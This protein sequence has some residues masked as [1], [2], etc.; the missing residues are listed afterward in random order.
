MQRQHHSFRWSSQRNPIPMW[1]VRERAA[2]QLV[3]MQHSAVR[4]SCLWRGNQAQRRRHW[5]TL[6]H[7]RVGVS[8]MV[9]PNYH[10]RPLTG[11]TASAGV[12]L[13]LAELLPVVAVIRVVVPMSCTVVRCHLVLVPQL[14]GLLPK[15][16]CLLQQVMGTPE[17]PQQLMGTPEDPVDTNLCLHDVWGVHTNPRASQ[18]DQLAQIRTD[19]RQL[20]LLLGFLS[21]HRCSDTAMLKGTRLLM[22]N[23]FPATCNQSHRFTPG[24][25]ARGSSSRSPPDDQV[26]VRHTC[27]RNWAWSPQS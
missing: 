20:F 16:H 18:H 21:H 2:N 7:P 1:E 19:K 14:Q 22:D 27:V 13:A 5:S 9:C 6:Y 11:I 3:E 25:Y 24:M 26:D 17:E 8:R 23:V 12:C 4:C 10:S 15:V